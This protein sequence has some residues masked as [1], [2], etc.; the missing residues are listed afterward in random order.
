MYTNPVYFLRYILSLFI[1]LSSFVA[2]T[3]MFPFI[4]A[5][6]FVTLSNHLTSY[7]WQVKL[8]LQIGFLSQRYFKCTHKKPCK[9]CIKWWTL[10][11]ISR[12]KDS[13]QGCYIS[14]CQ[15]RHWV[16]TVLHTIFSFI[17]L[18]SFSFFPHFLSMLLCQNTI[19]YHLS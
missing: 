5:S 7:L 8:I 1:C 2:F 9:V 10:L 14:T 3:A 15:D 4:A 12:R 18:F 13:L 17:L 16:I 6:Y 19:N 11:L